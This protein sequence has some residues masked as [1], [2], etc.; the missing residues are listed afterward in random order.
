MT[1]LQLQPPGWTT[2]FSK[3]DRSR[4]KELICIPDGSRKPLTEKEVVVALRFPSPLNL[5]FARLSSETVTDILELCLDATSSD[6]YNSVLEKLMMHGGGCFETRVASNSSDNRINRVLNLSKARP[7][8][9]EKGLSPSLG[10][11][12]KIALSQ[13]IDRPLDILS[14]EIDRPLDILSRQAGKLRRVFFNNIP[15][16]WDPSPFTFIIELGLTNSVSRTDILF[17]RCSSNLET[18]RLTN[19]KFVGAVAQVLKDTVPL[20]RQTE[21]VLALARG[22]EFL[23][24]IHTNTNT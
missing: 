9:G 5:L 17:L 6:E 11:A 12:V 8:F 16:L 23:L 1:D 21:L 22:N 2:V 3:K 13:E 24:L 14:Q 4:V 18:L 20:P 7:S 19:A 10:V 15:C